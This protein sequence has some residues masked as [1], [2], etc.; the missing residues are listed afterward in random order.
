M[1]DYRP[2][3]CAIH[4][5]YELAILQGRRLCLSWCGPDGQHHRATLLLEDLQIR[6][7]AE[8]LIAQGEDGRSQA[9]R[10]DWISASEPS[11]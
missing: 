5:G 1:S 10:L 3:A 2:I 9:L 6:D 7:G 4:S 11:P 8:Y